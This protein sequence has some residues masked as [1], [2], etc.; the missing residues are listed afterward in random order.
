MPP[1][2]VKKSLRQN[3]NFRHESD[4]LGHSDTIRTIKN[5]H[6]DDM[7]PGVQGEIALVH[8]MLGLAA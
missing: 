2:I 6:I 1:S 4:Q 8:E 3:H 5:H 7:K